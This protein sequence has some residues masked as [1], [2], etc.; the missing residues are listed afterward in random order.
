MNIPSKVIK[1]AD[2]Y[3]LHRTA[4]GKLCYLY[5][6]SVLYGILN[7][8]GKEIPASYLQTMQQGFAYCFSFPVN[9]KEYAAGILQKESFPASGNDS[10][11][12]TDEV[13][14]FHSVGRID[15]RSDL[16]RFFPHLKEMDNVSDGRIMF[17]AWKKWGKECVHRLY[18]DWCFAV[19]DSLNHDLFLA[20]DHT[21]NTTLFF[22]DHPDYFA[23]ASSMKVMLALPFCDR[24]V[25]D[26]KLASLMT[27]WKCHASHTS[28]LH[29]HNLPPGYCLH[30]KNNS[31]EV[32][33]YWTP[34]RY[35]VN[36]SI[37]REEAL[38]LFRQLFFEAISCRLRVQKQA[39]VTLSS[40]LDSGA[41]TAAAAW[42]LGQAGKNLDAYTAIPLYD[43]KTSA[44]S[45]RIHNEIHLA[46][47]Y[48][49]LFPNLN[50]HKVQPPAVSILSL[51]KES[52]DVFHEPFSAASNYHWIDHLFRE[53][54]L[55]HDVLLCGQS[56]NQTISWPFQ[57]YASLYSVPKKPEI[58]LENLSHLHRFKNRILLPL[59]PPSILH[60]YRYYKKGTTPWRN[61]SMISP[62]LEKKISLAT[63]I[64][65][66]RWFPPFTFAPTLHEAQARHIDP[67]LYQPGY[68]HAPLSQVHG[69]QSLDPTIDIRLAEFCLTLPDHCYLSS[70]QHCRLL[71]REGMKNF[72]PAAILAN[73]ARGQQSSDI[74][75]RLHTFPDD[76]R[77]L[78]QELLS[79]PF[80]RDYLDLPRMINYIHLLIEKPEKCPFSDV[81]GFLRAVSVFFFL[82]KYL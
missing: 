26:L 16:S 41:V 22:Y 3:S 55:S 53:A 23:F 66:S 14:M 45:H 2:T 51:L 79:S 25:N 47:E 28:F 81:Y 15:N 8:K 9:Q 56:G 40:G 30:Q 1:I 52:I 11:L 78:E 42:I 69:I 19:Y 27:T 70:P 32:K 34:Y 43:E 64:K 82:Q 17:E 61:F 71:V 39:A 46:E 59:I 65:T 57:I 38:V 20:R 58:T 29:I 63:Q 7:K 62:H 37:E 35:E 4:E 75:I 10:F 36:P 73:T 77:T 49:K 74:I 67:S 48:K 80:A 21:G 6:M 54:A 60:L 50:I 44:P 24:S 13:F 33:P 12:H 68:Y 5:T 76:L 18:G 72:M 31:V